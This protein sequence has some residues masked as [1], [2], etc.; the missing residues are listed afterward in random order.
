MSWVLSVVAIRPTIASL[1]IRRVLGDRLVEAFGPYVPAAFR[2]DE[3]GAYRAILS[4]LR[5]TLPSRT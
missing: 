1:K 3:L 5:W 2:V 4:P